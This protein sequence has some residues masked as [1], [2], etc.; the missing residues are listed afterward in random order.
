[1]KSRKSE[2]FVWS[3][4]LSE[5]DAVA[6]PEDYF[7]QN[8]VPPVNK[9]IVGKKIEIPDPRGAVASWQLNFFYFVDLNCF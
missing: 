5:T 9:F 7:F 1:M 4:Y 3:D 6:A 8:S 2:G